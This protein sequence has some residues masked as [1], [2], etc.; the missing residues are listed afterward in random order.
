M[1]INHQEKKYQ[2]ILR[3]IPFHY[4]GKTKFLAENYLINKL[5]RQ[6]LDIALAEFLKV[7]QIVTKKKII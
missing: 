3:K 7:L 4:Y 5:K 6:I 2:K 1:Y